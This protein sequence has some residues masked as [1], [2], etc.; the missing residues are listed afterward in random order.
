MR[1]YVEGPGSKAAAA[2]L[3]KGETRIAPELVIAEVANAAWKL[4]RVGAIEPEHSVRIVAALPSAFDRLVGHGA[5]AVRALEIARELDHPVYDSL[6]LALAEAEG[7]RMVTADSRL[8]N[9][10]ARTAW[11]ELVVR[12]DSGQS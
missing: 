3:A 6:Y 4:A 1:W 8:L 2:L 11:E 7:A 12:L 9:R 5:I 10:V